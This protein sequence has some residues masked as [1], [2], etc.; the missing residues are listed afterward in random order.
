[1][2]RF[3]E[4]EKRTILHILTLIMEADSVI[5]PK[6]IDYINSLMKDFGLSSAEFD[7]MEMLDFDLLKKE[8]QNMSEEKQKTAQ[9]YFINMAKCDGYIH[10]NEIELINKLF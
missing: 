5:H 4:Q 8:Y 7:H 2:N 6:E 3:N 1:M 9:A 10:P